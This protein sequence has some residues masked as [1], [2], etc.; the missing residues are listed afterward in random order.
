MFIPYDSSMT[1][2]FSAAMAALFF[3]TSCASSTK[4]TTSDPKARIY[5]D[6]EF[7]GQGEIIYSD[8]K[9]SGSITQLRIEKDGCEPLKTEFK[10][11]EK[12]D[13]L[14]I[15]TGVLLVPLLWI[16]KYHPERSIDFTCQKKVY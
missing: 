2:L 5:V 14:A 8:T 11:N 13:P 1:R 16:K 15:V 9:F 6:G 4:I 7:Y 12:V 10:R 3:V